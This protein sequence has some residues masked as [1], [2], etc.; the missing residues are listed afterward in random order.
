MAAEPPPGPPAGP[1]RTLL[2]DD[3]PL[4]RENLRLRL[5]DAPDF[6][7]V[8]EC[9]TGREAVAA[10]AALRPELMF[11]DIHMPD[12]DGLSVVDLL[13]PDTLPVV[14]FVTAYDRH[15]LE[16][17]RVHALDYLLK[18]FERGRFRQ[19]LDACRRRVSEVR[20]LARVGG[21][22]DAPREAHLAP[23]PRGGADAPADRLVVKSLGRVF[24][25]ATAA[26]DWIEANADY[27]SLHVGE[28]SWL[29]R[30]TMAEMEARLDPRRFARVSRSAIVNLDRVR[31]LR[32]AARG[33]RLLRLTTGRELK[34]TR[35]HRHRLEAR[36][37]ARL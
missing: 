37:R 3:E 35:P 7:V 20:E 26:V 24:F 6:E 34:L 19:A 10:V 27:V 23:G 2:V 13:D 30:S 1:I 29:L 4:A 28:R 31:E 12:M 8:G 17:F 5:R 11:L 25:V 14:V 22:P 36:L 32:P 9:G 16:A 18:P 15:A 21:R 33:E